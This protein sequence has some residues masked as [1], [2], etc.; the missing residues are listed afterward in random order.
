MS[1]GLWDGEDHQQSGGGGGVERPGGPKGEPCECVL[2]LTM[3]STICVLSFGF[4]YMCHFHIAQQ[5]GRL[6][7]L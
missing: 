3:N 6:P 5:T 4:T 1:V 2:F 7:P